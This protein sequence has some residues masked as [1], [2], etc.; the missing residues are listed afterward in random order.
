VTATVR[1]LLRLLKK[2]VTAAEIDSVSI[3]H[4]RQ[5]EPAAAAGSS[6]QVVKP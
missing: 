1:V 3:E 2:S 4:I 5:V 6:A